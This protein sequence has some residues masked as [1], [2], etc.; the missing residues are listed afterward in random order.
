MP[1]VISS[2][3]QNKTHQLLIT[4]MVLFSIKIRDI[5]RNLQTKEVKLYLDQNN[6]I[7]WLNYLKHTE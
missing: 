5:L 7:Q 6:L 4:R 2:I 3:Y 1:T